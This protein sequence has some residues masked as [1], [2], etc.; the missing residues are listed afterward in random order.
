VVCFHWLLAVVLVASLA[1]ALSPVAYSQETTAGIQGTVK[2]AQGGTVPGAT[3]EVTGPALIGKKEVKTDSSGAYR[4]TNLPP[5]EYTLTITVPNFRTYK[6]TGIDLSAG[7]LPTIDAQ[8]EIGTTTQVV[9][10]SAAAPMVDVTES[11]AAVT[12]TQDILN[13]IPKGRSFQSVIAFAPGARQEPLQSSRD[14]RGRQNGFQIDGASDSENTYLVEGLD[15]SEV[16]NGGLGTGVPM[17]FVQEVQVKSSGFEAE[18][19]GAIGGVVNVIQKRGG[20]TW[21]GSVFAKYVTDAANANDQCINLGPRTLQQLF[22]GARGNPNFSQN[23]ALRQDRP[24]EYYY[25]NKDHRRIVE[26]GFEIG[27]PVLT[28]RLWLYI[29][30]LPTIDRDTRK[31]NFTGKNPGLRSFTRADDTHNALTRLDY[32]A[33]N[34][35]RLFASWQYGYRRIVGVNLPLFPDSPYGQKNT[36]ASTDPASLRSDTGSVN[37]LNVFN[38]GGD[39]MVT[40][41]L[42]VTSRFGYFFYNSEDRGKPVGI[43]HLFEQTLRPTDRGTP[44]TTAGCTGP[45]IDPTGAFSNTTGFAN[46]PSNFQNLFDALKRKA[47]ST[48]VSYY[49]GHFLGGTHS[50]KFGYGFNRLS[51]DVLQA[52]NIAL[53]TLNWNKVYSPGTPAGQQACASLIAANGGCRGTAGI[54]AVSDGVDTTGHV[55]SFN[56]S[57]Y[58][59][60]A[61]TIKHLTINAGVRFDKEFIPP[62]SAGA[63][64]VSFGFTDKIA[65][66]IGAAYDLLHNGKIKI[67]GSYGKFFDIMK[68]SLPRGSF[69]GEYWHDCVYAL[70]GA[71]YTTIQPTA[72]GGHACGTSGPAPGVAPNTGVVGALIENIDFRKNLLDPNFPGL[73]PNIKPQEQHEYVG[74]LDWAIK[75]AL[76]FEVRYARK[77]LDRTIEDIGITDDLGFYIGNPGTAYADL[78]HR[79]TAPDS[80]I[81]GDTPHPIECAACA[82]QPDARRRYDGLEFRL[83]KRPSDRWFGSVSYT[84]S[85][86]EGNYTG[87]TD[88][89]ITDGQGG[90]H[91]PNNHRAWDN[92]QMQFTS[93]GTYQDGPLPTDRPHTLKVF[94][95]YQLKWF[96]QETLLGL[97]QAAFSGTPIST[98]WNT[99]ATASSCVFVENR[100]N[101]VKLHVQPD[102]ANPAQGIFVSDGIIQDYRT[103]AFTQTDLMLSHTIKVSKTNENLRL[104]FEVNVQNVLNQHNP[105]AYWENPIQGGNAVAPAGTSPSGIDWRAFTNGGW[106]YTG[107]T[108]ATPKLVLDSVYGQPVIFQTARNMRFRIKFSF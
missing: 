16:K 33:F 74:G 59:Q 34:S 101:F 89:D 40:P 92:P 104:A 29:S 6:R 56:H 17:E 107:V 24:L 35:L 19:G 106:D 26:P 28:D 99:I 55:H 50:F 41:R 31:V 11:K 73:D 60:D 81:I 47:W 53:V 67:Y 7:R 51:E 54:F 105:L 65:P 95:A 82:P 42:V 14:D 85:K 68:Y 20:S 66:R 3:V 37:P 36:G 48:D 70:N 79:L 58:G 83:T 76:G 77:R 80:G 71:N 98:C 57:I 93:H 13:V 23:T 22:C 87:L 9:E 100:G 44:C 88:T 30:Y 49:V 91:S 75:P 1:L 61:W 78:L 27:G 86:L 2:D 64:Q 103:P 102:P 39:W 52:N 10:V 97:E 90:R 108:N 72:P 5:G 25:Q 8:L 62:F 4:F 15:T 84:Y 43:R 46:M 69:G 45:F 94:G 38:F 21:H 18:Y 96:H 63:N 32:R 12:V